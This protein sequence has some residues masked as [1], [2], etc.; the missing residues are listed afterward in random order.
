MG[1]GVGIFLVVL[2]LIF[3]LGVIEVDLPA[4]EDVTLG[5][6]LLIAGVV[7]I[8]LGLIASRNARTTRTVEER[9]IE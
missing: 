2:G 1:L 3:L 9:R 7:A 5:W 8:V 4:V 6:I